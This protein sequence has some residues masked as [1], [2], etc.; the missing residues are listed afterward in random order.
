MEEYLSKAK[1]SDFLVVVGCVQGNC[2]SSHKKSSAWHRV[3]THRPFWYWSFG[4]LCGSWSSAL[5][6]NIKTATW[7][8]VHHLSYRSWRNWIKERDNLQNLMHLPQEGLLKTLLAWWV[9]MEVF[10]PMLANDDA[11]SNCLANSVFPALHFSCLTDSILK[12]LLGFSGRQW[13]HNF[14]K[15]GMYA[16]SLPEKYHKRLIGTI[17]TKWKR[18]IKNYSA[19][20]KTWVKTIWSETIWLGEHLFSAFFFS[21]I[22]WGLGIVNVFLL[23]KYYGE[24]RHGK[25]ISDEFPHSLATELLI[26]CGANV[27]MSTH[28]HT[29]MHVRLVYDIFWNSCRSCTVGGEAE[30]G[31]EMV[32][33]TVFIATPQ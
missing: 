1:K 26:F 18:R 24:Y 3:S 31:A 23:F 27:Y 15:L 17:C 16:C 6:A 30:F 4:Q 29:W 2:S 12:N 7:T 19:S 25:Y 11:L 14:K 28:S 5:R 9:N 10:W 8:L 21:E 13:L 32:T 33:E 22:D 20:W